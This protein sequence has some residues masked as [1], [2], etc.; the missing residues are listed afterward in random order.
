M[1]NEQRSE[2]LPVHLRPSERKLLED[3]AKIDKRTLSDF[4]RAAGLEKAEKLT[5]AK[6]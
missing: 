3:G 5:G 1:Q 2:R 6:G 4:V